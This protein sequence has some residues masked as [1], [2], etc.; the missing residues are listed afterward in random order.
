MFFY[1]LFTTTQSYVLSLLFN[2]YTVVTGAIFAFNF[3]MGLIFL[4]GYILLLLIHQYC[5]EL[6]LIRFD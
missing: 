4:S 2:S 3:L 1:A 5:Y 6:L